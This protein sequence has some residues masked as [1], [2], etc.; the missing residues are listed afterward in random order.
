MTEQRFKSWKTGDSEF[1]DKFFGRDLGSF[2][3][4]TGLDSIIDQWV[5]ENL[6]SSFL[7]INNTN[8][9]VIESKHEVGTKTF[10]GNIMG[11]LGEGIQKLLY[12]LL[13]KAIQKKFPGF[14]AEGGWK[15]RLL[16]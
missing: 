14:R 5:L 11:K 3:I 2:N 4:E 9:E 15:D 8:E 7:E 16:R 1:D 10:A 13:N 12:P 6:S